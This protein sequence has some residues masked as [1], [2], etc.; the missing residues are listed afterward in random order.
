MKC[1]ILTDHRGHSAQNSLYALARTLVADPRTERVDIASRGLAAN[2]DFF[3]GGAARVRA[4]RATAGLS[5]PADA[6][7]AESPV[8]SRVEDYDLV[9]LRLP[10]PVAP[11]FLDYLGGL[12]RP[13]VV[14]D[15]VGLR[16]VGSKA[17]LTR[18]P[19]WTAPTL[20]PHSGAEIREFLTRHPLVMKPVSDYG[21]HGIVRITDGAALDAFLADHGPAVTA[22]GYV[23]MQFLPRVSEGDK[24][25]LVV[26]GEILAASLRV[27]KAGDWLCNV[28]RG[29]TSL[30]AEVTD[31]ERAMVE[32][33]RP[34]LR[35]KGIVFCGIDTLV[36]NDGHRVLSEINTL[37]IGGFPQAEAQTGQPIL[38]RAIDGLYASLIH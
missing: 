27:P 35:K 16:E 15:P 11:A 5:Y 4:I 1:L 10:H 9:W 38:Q 36:G 37:S 19:R 13:R 32:D 28:A 8:R 6:H 2:A 25:I 3:A 7:F 30:P 31:H 29:G 34:L 17:F 26:N 12:S 22:G 18:L 23:A 14:N 21:G 33:L 24:R 20:H